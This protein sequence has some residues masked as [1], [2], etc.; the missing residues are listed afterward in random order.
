MI[1]ESKIITDVT[2][3]LLS[4][5]DVK[6]ALRVS[7]SEDDA[8]L[9]S[10]ITAGRQAIEKY[11]SISIGTKTIK[12]LVDLRGWEQMVIPYPPI[13]MVT[14][15]KYKSDYG[16]YQNALFG[17]DYDID[18]IDAKM[19]VPFSKGRWELSYTAGMTVLADDLK[20]YWTRLIAFY[21]ENRGESQSIPD[22]I[23]RDLINYRQLD[24]L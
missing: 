3:E 6:T 1:V 17:E 23:K 14:T 7:H 21:Y 11:C 4:L 10:L 18:G 20:T 22:E 2:S 16:E 13:Q 19:F 24:W 8:Y 15:V 12:T 5:S 9:G